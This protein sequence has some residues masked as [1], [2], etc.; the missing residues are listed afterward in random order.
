MNLYFIT[1]KL[2]PLVTTIALLACLSTNVVFAQSQNKNKLPEI[3]AAAASVLSLD[4]E[5]QIGD[6]MM[7]QLRASQPIINDPVLIE[8]INHLGNRLVKNAQD[9]NYRFKFFLINRKAINAFAFFGGHVAVHSSLVTLADNESELASVLAH[10]I[11]HVTQRHLARRLESQKRSQPLT[12]AGMISGVL[13]A[14][15]NPTIGF[16]ALTTTIAASKQLSIN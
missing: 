7:R 6:I 2:K 11:S 14:L 16:A 10:E 4:K 1:K 9:V 8:Y 3:G 15:V 12:T 5:R 13:L